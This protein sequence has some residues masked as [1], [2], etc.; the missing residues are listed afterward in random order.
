MLKN[1]RYRTT[2]APPTTETIPHGPVTNVAALPQPIYGEMADGQP[3]KILAIGNVPGLSP[4][5]LVCDA[6]G[7]LTWVSLGDFT[8]VDPNFLPFATMPTA[9]K[10]RNT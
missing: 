8:V 4:G 1:T 6:D 9:R 3:I 10:T 7:D 5:G 2:N